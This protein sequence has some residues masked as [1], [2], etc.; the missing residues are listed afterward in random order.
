VNASYVTRQSQTLNK[1]DEVERL[2][3]RA[4][5]LLGEDPVA[6]FFAGTDLVEPG[7]VRG[8]GAAA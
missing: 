5:V 2:A 4:V 1:L 8:G 6:R 7:T 3:S